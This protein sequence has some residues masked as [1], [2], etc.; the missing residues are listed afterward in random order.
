MTIAAILVAA[1]SGSQFGAETPKQFLQLGTRQVIRHA[2]E[3]LAREVDLLQPVGD[4]APIDAALTGM[5]YLPVVAGGAHRQASVLAGLEALAPHRPDLVLVHDAARPLSPPEPSPPAA[6]LGH[7]PG[8]IPAVP[9]AD[10]LKRGDNGRIVETVP[11]AGLFRAQTPQAFISP[12]CS[13]RIGRQPPNPPPTTP[14]ARGRRPRGPSGA[15]RRGE[16][17]TDLPGR[18]AAVGARDGRN[19]AAAGRHRIRRARLRGRPAPGAV[20]RC[21]PHPRAWRATRTPMSASISR[22][23]LRRAGRGRYRPPFPSQRGHR[24]GRRQRAVP[25]R[26]GRADRGAR[27]RP[28]HRRRTLSANGPKI[29]RMPRQ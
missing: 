3:A 8:A 9:V 28:R 21:R 1:G 2:A 4:A 7:A 12:P 23:G 27:R 25:D 16:H 17:Q 6:A 22:R 18:L 5:K 14:R 11:R 13:R 26:C 10:T 20:R 29:S 24:E 15:R 19:V